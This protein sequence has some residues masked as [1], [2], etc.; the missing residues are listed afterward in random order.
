LES[1]LGKS[2]VDPIFRPRSTKIKLW[3]SGSAQWL[4]VTVFV[5]RTT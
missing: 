1:T 3:F 2:E 5:L 4:L